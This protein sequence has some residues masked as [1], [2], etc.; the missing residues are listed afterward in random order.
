MLITG[1]CVY[2]SLAIECAK[3]SGW[4]TLSAV[5]LG[6]ADCRLYALK[7]RHFLAAVLGR[8]LVKI[9]P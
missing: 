1:T 4:W 7:L 6:G 2:L 5:L 9:K 3:V 8:I